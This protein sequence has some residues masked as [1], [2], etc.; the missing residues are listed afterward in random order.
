MGASLEWTFAYGSNMDVDDLR[1]WFIANGHHK[2]RIERCEP[3]TLPGFRLVWNYYSQSRKGGAA[4]IERFAGA[5]LP[6]VALHVN[7]AGLAA[8][9]RKEGHPNYYSRGDVPVRA[10]LIGGTSVEAWVYV[11]VADRCRATEIPPTRAYL[12]MMIR[13]AERVGLP[14]AHVEMLRSTPTMESSDG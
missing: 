1:S 10:Q 12:D 3:A 5:V 6:G 8:I 7:G 11:A 13:A 14:A 2:A 4:N 9:D